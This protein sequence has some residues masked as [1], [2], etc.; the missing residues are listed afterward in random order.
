MKKTSITHS[1][2]LP[3]LSL[4]SEQNLLFH[5][6]EETKNN[7][8]IQGQA[9]T[10]KSTFIKYLF[11]NS[12][13]NIRIVCPTA[14]AAL[15]IGGVTIH[16][17]FQLPLSD[18]IIKEQLELKKKTIKILKKTDIIIIDEISMVRPDIIDA[19]DYILQQARGE[20]I[21][22]GGVQMIFVGDL[23]Q[24]PPVIK[25]TATQIFKHRY[26]Y[27]NAYFFDAKSF[28]QSDFYFM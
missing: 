2:D 5:K 4:S 19:I 17:L 22:F 24:L 26:G 13:K 3:I 11:E 21:P 1:S 10:G 16:S 12:S 9:G 15:H 20:F 8:F 27:E 25:Q 14:I 7:Y 18:F 28:K 23:C 6:I